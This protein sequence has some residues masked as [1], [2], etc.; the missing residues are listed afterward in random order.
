MIEIAQS[1]RDILTGFGTLFLCSPAI[2]R[3]SSLMPI[4]SIS[5]EEIFEFNFIYGKQVYAYTMI[6]VDDGERVLINSI[7]S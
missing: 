1:R 3:S 7:G 6:L 4:R 5:L 2:V